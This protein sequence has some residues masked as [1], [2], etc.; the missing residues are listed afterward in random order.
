MRHYDTHIT[1]IVTVV[2]A[3]TFTIGASLLLSWIYAQCVS[4]VLYSLHT[5]S[6]PR[7]TVVRIQT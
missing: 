6:L 1:V 2:T 3:T 5:I 4:C 7:N